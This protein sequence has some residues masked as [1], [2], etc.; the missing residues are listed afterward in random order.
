MVRN[1]DRNV[2]PLEPLA[3]HFGN[4]LL[5]TGQ[6]AGGGA[7]EGADRLRVNYREL[8]V[9]ELA[10]RL[11]F[12]RFRGAVIGWP[13]LHDVANVD[14]LAKDVDAFL[15]GGALDHLRQELAGA[16]DERNA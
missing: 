14:V 13:A 5:A 6:S 4:A 10:A 3:A 8:P 16:A 12:A 15:L 11:H 7:A 9:K 2:A 1:H